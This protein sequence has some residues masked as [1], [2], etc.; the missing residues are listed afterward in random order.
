MRRFS[1]WGAVFVMLWRD[2]V[3]SF[4]EVQL[5]LE[6]KTGSFE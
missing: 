2:L 1:I 5:I 3:D 4:E 6:A